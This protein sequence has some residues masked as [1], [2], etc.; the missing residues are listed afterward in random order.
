MAR[1]LVALDLPAGQALVDAIRRTWDAGDAIVC[2]DRRLPPAAAAQQWNAAAPGAVIGPDGERSPLA[3]GR[4]VEDGDAVV[5]CTSGT[6]GAPTAV[7]HT[8]ASVAASA[9]ATSAALDVDPD[10]DRWLCCLPVAHIGGL[11]VILRALVTGTPLDVHAGFDPAAV[12]RAAAGGATLVSLV[13]RA[14]AR[15][16]A[17]AFRRILLG[18]GPMPPERPVNTVATYGMTET[19]SG[20]VYEGWPLA[21]VDVA[22]ADD[23]EI[24]LRCPMLA[25]ARRDGSALTGTDGWFHTGDEG[26]LDGDGRLSVLGRRGDVIATG[27]EKVWPERLEPV[28]RTVPGVGEV[29]VVGRPDPEWGQRVVAVV[30]VD[31]DPPSVDALAAAV[32]AAG[33]PVWYRP[34]AVEVRAD[35]PR[36]ALGK[37]RRVAL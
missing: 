31:G 9:E 3:G 26:A 2:V 25:G 18:G 32:D 28:L 35:L 13:T 1:T 29:A 14:L 6:T 37:V 36:T 30:V 12:D 4:P 33:L 20:V 19:G 15:V 10:R 16:D 17:A 8:H 34:R 22:V 23:G 11:S 7:V 5:V 27:G 24:L 21:G